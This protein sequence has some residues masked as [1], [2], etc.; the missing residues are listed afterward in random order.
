[1]GD[2]QNPI[3]ADHEK[4]ARLRLIRTNKIG[5]A[6][7]TR[8]LGRYG[9]AQNALDYLASE[10]PNLVVAD[11]PS[12]N[13][14]FDAVEKF[15]GKFLFLG[16]RNYPHRLAHIPDTPPVLAVKGNCKVYQNQTIGV[17]G[18]RNASAS[19]LK[20][21]RKVCSDLSAHQVTIVSGLARGIDTEA[22]KASLTGGTIAC[23]AGGLDI[24]Y[25]PENQRLYDEIAEKGLLV[26]EMPLGT[27]PQARH[28]PRRNRIISGLS[29]G[30]LVIEAA[31]KSGSLIT[32][33]YAAD[34]GRDVFAVP[35]SPLDPRAQGTNQL[36]K[37]GAILTQTAE[38]ILTELSSMPLLRAAPTLSHQAF[39]R[40]TDHLP[41]TPTTNQ[42][43]HTQTSTPKHNLL[44][45]LSPDPTHIDEIV[46]LSGTPTEVILSEF[47]ALE[48]TGEIIRH[49]GNRFSRISVKNE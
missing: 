49:S 24:I 33:R 17:V 22:H 1:M 44:E 13:A 47:I 8:L 32:A 41:K 43:L 14:E 31:R 40:S 20:L 45:Y 19:G 4:L 12:I 48:L 37:D 15:G 10:Q 6:T 30:L 16:E 18:A 9:T 26:S 29:E 36:I 5:P 34:Q 2:D 3:L 46:R 25:P 28:F 23:L 42:A 38:D 21:T 7:Y 11:E 39:N 35:G 27:K